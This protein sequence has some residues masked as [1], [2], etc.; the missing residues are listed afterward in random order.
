[1]K[2]INSFPAKPST[3]VQHVFDRWENL[4]QALGVEATFWEGGLNSYKNTVK[5]FLVCVSNLASL[6]ISVTLQNEQFPDLKLNTQA[7]AGLQ[8]GTN[9]QATTCF[10]HHI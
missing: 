2:K 7:V 10:Q 9:L 4:L 5:L 8:A 6:S 3:V 1:M